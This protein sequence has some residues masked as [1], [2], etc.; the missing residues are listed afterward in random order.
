MTNPVTQRDVAQACGLHPSTVCLALKNAPSIPLA[1]RQRI[2]AAAAELGYQPNVAARNLAL[3]RTE[4]KG[5]GSLPLAWINQEPRPEH[6]HTDPEAREFFEGAQRRAEEA[7]YHLEEVWA[8]E[9]G[10]TPARLVQILRARGIEGVIFP[11]HRR[12]DFALLHPG[13]NEFALVGC[14]D[15]RLGEWVDVVCADYYRN[16]DLVWRRLRQLGFERIGLVLDPQGDAASDG[17]VHGSFLRRQAD[18]G[19]AERVP[20]C[21]ASETSDAR[22]RAFA[23]WCEEQRPDVIVAR[24]VTLPAMV[25]DLGV[26]VPCVQ[27]HGADAGF[28]A[29]LDPAAAEIAAAAVTCLVEKIRRF[30]K[31]GREATRLQLLKGQ[32]TERRLARRELQTVVA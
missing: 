22:R 31:G 30:E 12:F 16:L 14:N 21:F 2:H 26:D 17:L 32:W 27:W 28:D 7:G 24:D 9:P 4:K 6:W 18:L 3:L 23:E 1:T 19:P 20:V 11:V 15:L 13:W 25:R 8:R 5:S 29:N 10:M